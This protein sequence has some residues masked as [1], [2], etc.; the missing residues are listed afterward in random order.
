MKD[1][2]TITNGDRV[3]S[4]R[5]FSAETEAEAIAAFR[6]EASKEGSVYLYR[7]DA[8]GKPTLIRSSETPDYD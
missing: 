8:D 1:A 7:L 6:A 4:D 2:I 5:E 3:F